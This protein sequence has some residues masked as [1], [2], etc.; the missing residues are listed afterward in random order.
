[1]FF[2]VSSQKFKNMHFASCPADGGK[3]DPIGLAALRFGGFGLQERGQFGC[4]EAQA[5]RPCEPSS[6]NAA[7]ADSVIASSV[8][9]GAS[10]CGEWPAPK[11]S[12]TSTGQ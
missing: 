8:A 11:T 1:M 7:P 6:R 4:R 3:A 9:P 12:V 10:R 5:A 2:D